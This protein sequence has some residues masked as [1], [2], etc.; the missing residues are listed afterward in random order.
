LWNE[1]AVLIT[2]DEGG[3]FYGSGYIQPLD[4]FGEA[5]ESR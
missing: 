1:T 5:H 3:G 2:F 4:Y